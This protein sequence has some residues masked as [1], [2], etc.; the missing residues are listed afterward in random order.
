MIEKKAHGRTG[1]RSDA[2]TRERD[3]NRDVATTER[4]CLNKDVAR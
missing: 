4:L 1:D 3:R 2:Q